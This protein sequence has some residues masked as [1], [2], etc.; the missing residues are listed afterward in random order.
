MKVDRFARGNHDSTSVDPT[1]LGRVANGRRRATPPA[2]A[3]SSMTQMTQMMQMTRRIR[4]IRSVYAS[5]LTI[6]V[7]G[8]AACAKPGPAQPPPE[9]EPP[10]AAECRAT[11][12]SGT[13][14]ASEDVITTC[15][16]RPEYACYQSA[17]CAAQTDGQCG[18][19]M[20]PE[21]EACLANP[22]DEAAAAPADEA[23]Q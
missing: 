21:L 9:V 2:G 6:A 3:I 22:P 16:F 19:T 7:V 20:T 1:A 23:P 11:G 17:A 13:V 15:E 5:W 14:C 18:W 12:C 8:M 10:P 4:M